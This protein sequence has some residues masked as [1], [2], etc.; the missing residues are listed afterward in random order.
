M[1]DCERGVKRYTRPKNS[2]EAIKIGSFT[3]N[4]YFANVDIYIAAITIKQTIKAEKIG[5]FI[6]LI[7]RNNSAMIA[8]K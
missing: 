4:K 7:I 8:P 2:L 5:F 1:I 6:G 3:Q